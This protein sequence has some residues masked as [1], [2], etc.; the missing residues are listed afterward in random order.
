MKTIIIYVNF[1]TR[2]IIIKLI[3]HS[4][5][6]SHFKTFLCQDTQLETIDLSRVDLTDKPAPSLHHNY[7]CAASAMATVQEQ[8]LSEPLM[9]MY[10]I[11]VKQVIKKWTDNLDIDTSDC[12]IDL[13]DVSQ[14]ELTRYRN[15]INNNF[16]AF[17]RL[18]C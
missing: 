9:S 11:D 15:F 14:G 13:T 18:H 3:V 4:S 12:I 2:E 1:K 6:P 10:T 5:S 16:S 8:Q 17:T 7:T